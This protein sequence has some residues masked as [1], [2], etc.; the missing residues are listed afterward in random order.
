MS[1]KETLRGVPEDAPI[2]GAPMPNFRC[3]ESCRICG[4]TE[5]MPVIN[6]GEQSLTGVFPRTPGE[7]ITRGP[8]EV[9]RC[10]GGS[11]ACGLVQLRHSYMSGE[12]YGESYGYRSSLNQAM[13]A[14]LGTTVR[15]VTSLACPSP[16][17]V[18]IDVGS[19]DGTTLSFFS[20]DLVRV[21]IDPMSAKFAEFYDPSIIRITDFFS[22]K[23]I[24]APLGSRKAKIITSI[25]MFYDLENPQQ[26]V[27]EIAE[28]LADDGLWYFEQSY[29]PLMLETNAYDTI[30][31]DHLE[32][33]AFA[34]VE[35]LLERSG[36]RVIDVETNDVNGGSFAVAAVKTGSSVAQASER[37]SALRRAEADAGLRS[38]KPFDEFHEQV[39]IHRDQLR[40]L[41]HS[42]NDE[43]KTL[44]GYGASTKGNV[45]LQFCDFT[46]SD[47][48]CIA[49]VN[50]DKFGRVTPGTLIPIISES[51]A[52]AMNP[53]YF[54][55][56]PWHFRNNLIERE[57]DYLERGGRMIFP[58]PEIEIVDRAS[59]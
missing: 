44:I 38:P 9:V 55:A 12:M 15:K 20:D 47:I 37:V 54:L 13:V 33:Y 42:I 2:F 32:Y 56:L 14:H 35:W 30:C 58:L 45:L 43:G 59:P 53:D 46:V 17:D 8:L 51:E 28:S 25:A 10:A 39:M 21:G 41:V 4:N 36:L 11:G 5:L 16:G 52:R 40:G 1:R 26:F 24:D 22:A 34:Q 48:S 29:M 19:N 18:V 6:L 3:I 31:H 23:A 50:S 27:D 57:R 7:Q 49:E